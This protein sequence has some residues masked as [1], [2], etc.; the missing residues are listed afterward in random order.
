ML[1][2]GPRAPARPPRR[3]PEARVAAETAPACTAVSR[4]SGRRRGRGAAEGGAN[5]AE[6]RGN[7]QRL[8][9]QDAAGGGAPWRRAPWSAL[10]G[11][12]SLP[13]SLTTRTN[14]VNF[15]K[16]ILSLLSPPSFQ[17]VLSARRDDKLIFLSS[18]PENARA[19]AEVCKAQS[20][21]GGHARSLRGTRVC[22]QLEGP[23]DT[24]G[25]L[26]AWEPGL[27]TLLRCGAP[28]RPAAHRAERGGA[29]SGGCRGCRR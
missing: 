15:T 12:E 11:F 18:L 6:G 22:R 17:D 9:R 7:T 20:G 27:A 26:L 13:A 24:P 10:R 21:R 8:G 2:P 25:V 4:A 14:R 19:P 3:S 16:C 28:A 5:W 29:A 23:P 1:P